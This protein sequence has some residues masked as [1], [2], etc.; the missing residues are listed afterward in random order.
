MVDEP[1]SLKVSVG[2]NKWVKLSGPSAFLTALVLILLG[3]VGYLMHFNL[4]SWGEPFPI[5][6]A[7]KEINELVIDHATKMSRQHDD[8]TLA[9]RWNTFVQWACSPSNV[10]EGAKKK[11]S[12]I[13]LMKPE[14]ESQMH[15]RYR[16]P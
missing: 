5:K 4:M 7:F 13:D 2:E 8:I 3:V 11:C 9:L 6:S 15:R 14:P 16:V 10:S 1:Q 12:E